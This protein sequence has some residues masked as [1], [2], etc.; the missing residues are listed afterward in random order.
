M[1]ASAVPVSHEGMTNSDVSFNS[2][3]DCAVDGPQKSDVDYGQNV[4]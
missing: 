2:Q 1:S 4:R 3:C